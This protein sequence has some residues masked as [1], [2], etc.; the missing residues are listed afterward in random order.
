MVG[1]NATGSKLFKLRK[2]EMLVHGGYNPHEGAPVTSGI[3]Y[4]VAGFVGHNRHCCSIV[5]LGWAGVF[6]FIRVFMLHGS[7]D[8]ILEQIPLHEFMVYQEG[9]DLLWAGFKRVVIWGSV[10][11]VEENYVG[12]LN[13]LWKFFARGY[14][15]YLRRSGRGKTSRS[16]LP[17]KTF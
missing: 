2:G 4:I 14:F 12:A 17:E 15:W 13:R 9:K 3:R 1:P 8:E 5:Y 11:A 16:I 6:A 10:L 7:K